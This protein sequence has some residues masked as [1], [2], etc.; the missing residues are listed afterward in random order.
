MEAATAH[1]SSVKETA[2]GGGEDGHYE[3]FFCGNV[4]WG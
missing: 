4:Q 1:G 3:L 2:R